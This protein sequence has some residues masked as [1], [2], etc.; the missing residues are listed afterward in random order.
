[1]TKSIFIC[2]VLT[3]F[4]FLG[5]YIS[6]LTCTYSVRL[7]V[8]KQK[9]QSWHNNLKSVTWQQFCNKYVGLDCKKAQNQEIPCSD[10]IFSREEKAAVA[11][12]L[13]GCSLQ[14]TA[15]V[16]AQPVVLGCSNCRERD[17]LSNLF[18]VYGHIC[19]THQFWEVAVIKWTRPC[20]SL[21]I[22]AVH[23]N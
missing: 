19:A 2:Y 20:L 4:Q 14:S 1:M 18:S 22:C 7:F 13:P 11:G 9:P 10:E 21:D 5:Q 15:S 12:S 3:I 6:H 8:V 17:R 16:L 23:F